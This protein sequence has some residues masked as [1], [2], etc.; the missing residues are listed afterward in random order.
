MKLKALYSF[1]L[2][3]LFFVSSLFAQNYRIQNGF[4]IYGGL[5]Q[6]DIE[7][8]SLVT[9]KDNGWLVGLAATVDLP[10]KWYN[11]SYNIQFS[12]NKLGI[13]A[14]SAGGSQEEAVDYKLFTAQVALLGHLKLIKNHITIDAGPML[15]YNSNL[16]IQDEAK[17][18]YLVSGYNTITAKDISEISRF[19][20]NG[21]VGVSAG[22]DKFK[23]RAQYIYGFTNMLNKLNNQNFSEN[24]DF[25]GNQSMLVFSAMVIF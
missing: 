3:S 7:T 16:D 21:A 8:N 19:N 2:F 11:V 25:K 10:H 22:F 4:G 12:E 13:L 14:L 23:V 1:A 9:Q 6:F 17:E 18:N 24:N 20:V 5:T 15:Q